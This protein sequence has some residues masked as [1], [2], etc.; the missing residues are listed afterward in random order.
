MPSNQEPNEFQKIIENFSEKFHQTHLGNHRLASPLGAWCLLAFVSADDKDP[1]PCVLENLGCSTQKAKEYLINL[2]LTKP[3]VVSFA[4][5]SWV[6][7]NAD[8]GSFNQ[9]IDDVKVF[10]HA[11]KSIPKKEELDEWVDKESL[12][13]IKE[14]PVDIS[15][16]EFLALFA[17]VVATDITWNNPYELSQDK[18]MSERWGVENCLVKYRDKD[19]FFTKDGNGHVYAVHSSRTVENDLRVFSVVSLDDNV[20]EA[21]TM[22]MARCVAN[23]NYDTFYLENLP[24]GVTY[25]GMLEVKEIAV[26][27]PGDIFNVYLPAWE[28]EETFDLMES[29]LGFDKVIRRFRDEGPIAA[30]AKQVVTAKYN[31]LGFKAAALSY[32]MV[33][34][35]AAIA[36]QSIV[37]EVTLRYNRPYAVV[38]T[39]ISNNDLWDYLTIFD[40]WISSAVEG[41]KAE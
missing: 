27:N 20:T 7:P 28:V 18:V 3:D 14:F 41:E 1:H 5:N 35:S 4:V 34:R 10:H 31:A 36:T 8:A 15:P 12:G 19:T 38:A 22:A 13:L 30:D 40:G 24:L 33:G 26:R 25:G 17:T 2:L 6:N 37:R 23:N 16:K 21:E 32:V 39:T 11:H 29:K 9:W